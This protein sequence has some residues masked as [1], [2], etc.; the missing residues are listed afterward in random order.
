M[1]SGLNGDDFTNAVSFIDGDVLLLGTVDDAPIDFA[2][3]YPTALPDRAPFC[4][5]HVD[6]FDGIINVPL[7]WPLVSPAVALGAVSIG[8]SK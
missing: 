1:R 3:A 6:L 2:G 8:L 7:G 5:K 4:F